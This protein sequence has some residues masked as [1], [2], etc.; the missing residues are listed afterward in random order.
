MGGS[1]DD[2]MAA[3]VQVLTAA[4]FNGVVYSLLNGEVVTPGFILEPTIEPGVLYLA[5]D[6]L[7]SGALTKDGS[8]K[9]RRLLLLYADALEAAGWLTEMKTQHLLITL[10]D[11]DG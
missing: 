7:T 10:S 4:G 8:E 1:V 3:A 11:L 6:R 2:L 5:R 9:A